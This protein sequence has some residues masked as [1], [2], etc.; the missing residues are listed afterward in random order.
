MREIERIRLWVNLNYS[1]TAKLYGM[2]VSTNGLLDS[3]G[4]PLSD[5]RIRIE[6]PA[7]DK[8]ILARGV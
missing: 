2:V 5:I 8:P 7:L 1:A 4:V 6:W 3:S